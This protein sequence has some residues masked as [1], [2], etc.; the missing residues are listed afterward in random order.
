MEKEEGMD[1]ETM[2]SNTGKRRGKIAASRCSEISSQRHAAEVGSHR[3]DWSKRTQSPPI[4]PIKK[5]NGSIT[6]CI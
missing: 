3:A 1:P 2:G 6:R 5:K 4:F